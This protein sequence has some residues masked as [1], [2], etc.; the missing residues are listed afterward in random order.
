MD[1]E[2]QQYQVNVCVVAPEHLNI[3]S[4]G[5]RAENSTAV[6]IAAQ[7]CLNKTINIVW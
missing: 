1:M 6:E 3:P 2:E 7:L 5:R 4:G